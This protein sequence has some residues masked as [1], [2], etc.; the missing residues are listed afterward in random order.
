MENRKVFKF[1]KTLSKRQ[2]N[3]CEDYVNSP[4][5][6]KSEEL[7]FIYTICKKYVLSNSN[8][9]Y[10]N[11]FESHF[12]KEKKT[13]SQ[14]NLDKY[15]SRIYLLALDFVGQE[16]LKEKE[17]L[18][19]SLLMEHLIDGDELNLFD[20]IYGKAKAELSKE[21][22]SFDNLTNKYLLQRLN[23]DY[24]SIKNEDKINKSNLQQTADTLDDFYLCQKY[25]L[26]LAKKNIENITNQKFDY[27]LIDPIDENIKTGQINKNVLLNLLVN[28]YRFKS[29]INP[30]L[31]EFESIKNIV[32]KNKN[33]INDDLCYNLVIL[34]KNMLYRVFKGKN[35]TYTKYI[36][37]LYRQF[38]ENGLFFHKGKMYLSVFKGV[39]DLGILNDELEWTKNFVKEHSMKLTPK[40]ISIDM[41]N[42]A[43]ARLEFYEGNYELAQNYISE[44]N[45]VGVNFKLALLRLEIMIYFELKEYVYLESLIKKFRVAIIPKRSKQLS[46]IHRELNK[47]FINWISKLIKIKTNANKVNLNGIENEF[48]PIAVPNK[49]WL[50]KK[51]QEAILNFSK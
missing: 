19:S 18:K 15:L 21:K 26:E 11:Y 49:L 1:L 23:A 17:F 14:K 32:I 7:C 36:F 31:V 50:S 10:Y 4:Y 40:N 30:T 42:Y 3:H 12:S 34:L 48:E 13:I 20:K 51:I 8:K 6:N 29:S 43:L 28:I 25:Y 5:F 41:K 45:F 27:H 9:N 2:L 37:T 39:V 44:A 38:L 46:E 24:E 33:Q 16:K 22:L 35:K 47:T